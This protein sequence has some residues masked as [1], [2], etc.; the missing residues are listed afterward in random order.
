MRV[1]YALA[2]YG[3]GKEV[4]QQRRNSFLFQS[5]CDENEKCTP[6][7]ITLEKGL[8]QFEA[9]GS[10]GSVET[11]CTDPGRGAYVKGSIYLTKE[12]TIYAF[13]G[14]THF[15]SINSSEKIDGAE[16]GGA[17]DIRLIGSEWV[18]FE[19]MKSRILV[20]AGGGGCEWVNSKGGYGSTKSYL[21]MNTS[22]Y[23]TG[24][25]QTDG[26]IYTN[27]YFDGAFRQGANGNFGFAG[28]SYIKDKGGMGG[29]GYYAGGSFNYA[30]GGGGG[31][32]YV[33]GLDGCNAISEQSSG[34]DDIQHTGKSEHYSGYS[35]HD[36]VAINGSSPMP[37]YRSTGSE[38]GNPYNG[39]LRITLLDICLTYKKIMIFSIPL[40]IYI[41][42]ML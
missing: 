4:V 15:G 32:S 34:Y 12:L 33:S 17:T 1:K 24:G 22:L 5:P 18:D 27:S 35:F 31:S 14:T 8:Y 37:S 36:I 16:G 19:S 3:L 26:G 11:R 21:S 30:G 23:T 10:V 7:I 29:G 20:A 40:F 9:W 2:D 28:L 39:A 13:I 38:I 41:M 42:I 25:N 6:Y